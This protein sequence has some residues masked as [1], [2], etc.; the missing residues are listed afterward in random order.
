MPLNLDN[1]AELKSALSNIFNAN[2]TG[3]G[4]VLLNYVGPSTL[5]FVGS[6][7]GAPETLESKLHDDQVQ[8]PTILPAYLNK[9]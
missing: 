5:H 4:W 1:Q 7:S 9:K 3:D 6:S 2:H 8:Y